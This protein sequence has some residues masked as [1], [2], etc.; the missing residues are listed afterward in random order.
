MNMRT[1]LK[2]VRHLGSAREG[3]DHFWMQRVTAVANLVLGL[4]LVWLIASLAGAD[5]VTVKSTLAN[6][7]VALLLAMLIV[8]AAIHMRLGMQVI[9]EDYI[10]REST[11]IVL[12]LLNNFFA[13]LVAA[14]S[15]WAILKLSFA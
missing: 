4:F 8:S 12:L 1:P 2:N 11:K 3:A 10:T 9:I 14:A 15:V 5:Y 6:P 13:I 7:I